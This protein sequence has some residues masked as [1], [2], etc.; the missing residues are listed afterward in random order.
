MFR[1]ANP[2]VSPKWLLSYCSIAVNWHHDTGRFWKKALNW[3][4]VGS[5][6]G[7]A[8]DHYGGEAG[9]HGAVEVSKNFPRWSAGRRQKERET[10][11]LQPQIL[12]WGMLQQG[13]TSKSFET[14]NKVFNIW[15]F[16]N[17]SQRSRWGGDWQ[18]R[19]ERKLWVVCKMNIKNKTKNNIKRNSDLQMKVL[20]EF[21]IR[22]HDSSLYLKVSSNFMEAVSQLRFLFNHHLII[23]ACIMLI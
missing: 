15:A 16:E 9:G 23:L 12:P 22:V 13:H 19:R 8:H 3:R 10:G 11:L 6:R 5:V 1:S 21:W 18:E 20:T 14:G 7:C 17:H 4:L 2:T